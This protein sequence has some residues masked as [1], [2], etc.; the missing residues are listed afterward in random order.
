M[1]LFIDFSSSKGR[2]VSVL[3]FLLISSANSLLAQSPTFSHVVQS[4]ASG[5]KVYLELNLPN[6]QQSVDTLFARI[7]GVSSGASSQGWGDVLS[8]GSNPGM[9]INFS[10]YDINGLGGLTSTGTLT[11]DSL[12]LNNDA[13]IMGR[14]SVTNVATFGDSLTVSGYVAFS[15]S[16]EVLKALTI[17]QTLHVTGITSLGDSLHVSGNVDLDALFNA[18]GAATFGSTLQVTGITTLNDS[19]VVN[20]G[21]RIA[22]SLTADSLS[23]TDVINGQIGDLS[24][25]S[26]DNLTE[27]SSNLYY[28]D[29][30]A[31]GSLAAGTGVTY[32]ESTGTIAIG[33][34]VGTTDNVS[35]AGVSAS[36]TVT[37]DSLSVTDVINGQIGDLSNH[38]TGNLTEGSNL[39]FTAARA[40]AALSDT[41]AHLIGRIEALESQ[42]PGAETFTCGTSTV[43]FD[44]HDYATVEIGTQCWFA[45][46][47]RSTKYNDDAVIPSGLNASAWSTT[48]DGAMTI[49]DEGGGSTETTNLT[50][51][52]RLYNWYAVNTGK[53]CPTGWHVPT[54]DEWSV[55][56]DYLGGESVAGDKMKSSASDSPAWNGTTSSGF[57]GLPGG[58]RNGSG[59]FGSAG[60]SGFWW[61]SSPD[62][63]LAW[64]R[65]LLSNSDSVLRSTYN[66]RGGFSVRCVRD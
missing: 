22:H 17:G 26:T 65:L 9:D 46:N 25:H 28:T 63:S 35:F 37:A 59:D 19:L 47:L 54:D 53:L 50:D 34:S 40:I 33:Q 42:S 23:V 36:A 61:S 48:T 16:L 38:N 10:G 39:Y 12:S 60:S 6:L 57:S 4:T 8:N 44:G 52:G 15:D 14:L 30:R 56:T 27:G 20:S 64:Y 55:L 62:G 31:R 43:T 7:D 1:S 66:Q 13:D 45:E 29:S 5:D 3:L 51:Y 58:R 41:I 11:A 21:A 32:T 18:E 49:Y 24:N 2:F